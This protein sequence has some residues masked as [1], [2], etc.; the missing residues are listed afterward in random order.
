MSDLHNML[1]GITVEG[2]S[3]PINLYD[4][5]SNIRERAKAW[6]SNLGKNGY[7][8]SQRLEEYLDNLTQNAREKGLLT[9]QEAFILLC[10][11]YLHD[12]GYWLNDHCEAVGHPERSRD[13]VMDNPNEYLL[14]DF[15]CMPERSPRVAEA[16]GLVCYGHSEERFR[17]LNEIPNDFADHFLSPELL[18]LRKLAALLR[19]ADEA[20]DPYIRLVDDSYHP[21]RAQT[22][23]VHIGGETIVWHWKHAGV[24]NPIEFL[25]H[26]TEKQEALV[27]SIDYLRDLGL[28]YWYLVLYPQVA[29]AAP[30]MPEDSVE[31]FVGREKDIEALHEV[32]RRRREGAITG[33]VGT[34]GIG[35]TE[36]AKM[37]AKR[38]RHEYLGGIFWASLKGSDWKSQAEKILKELRPG[39]RPLVFLDEARAK[40]AITSALDRRDGLLIIDNVTEL[41]QIV[42]PGCF[43]LV[44]S[45]DRQVFGIIPNEGIR[46]LSGLSIKEGIQLLEKILSPERV[47]IDIKAAERIIEILGGLPLAVEIAAKQLADA[48]DLSFS[49]YIGSVEGKIQKL[50]LEGCPDKDVVTSLEL[51]LE[52]L[53]GTKDGPELI[54]LFAALGVCAPSGFTSQTLGAA[55]G[56]REM[57]EVQIKKLVGKLYN[58]SLLEYI[59]ASMFFRVHPLLRQLAE[60][61]LN[62]DAKRAKLFVKNHCLHFLDYA[63]K[64]NDNPD[65]LIAE[66][67]G[68]WQA[69]IKANQLDLSGELLP[70]F[71]ANISRPYLTLLEDRKHEDAFRYLGKTILTDFNYIWP[72]GLLI[73]LLAPLFKELTALSIDSQA[74]LLVDMG[75][76]YDRLGE[77]R[78]A[79]EIGEQ[80]L[81]IYRKLG[82]LRG[83]G[84]VQGNIGASYTALREY[85][86][87]I[88]FQER[89]LEVF[90]RGTGN[91][92]GEGNALAN[93]GN[94]HVA[95]GDYQKAIGFY[96]QSLEIHR[97]I[98]YVQGQGGHLKGIGSCYFHFGEYQKAIKSY[99]QALRI[100]HRLGQ[101]EDEANCLGGM[102]HAYE[103]LGEYRKAIDL[104]EQALEIDRS[105]G[106]LHG[107]AR[108][109]GN[110]GAS[111][112]YLGEHPRAMEL[113]EQA[114]AL[115]RRLGDLLGEAH[116]LG[117]MGF[118][119]GSLGQHRKAIDFHE[120]AL[121][122][123]RKVGSLLSEGN[124]LGNIGGCYAALGQYRKAINFQEQAL[125]IHRRIGSLNDEGND[126]GDIGFAYEGLGEYKKAIGFYSQAIEIHRRIGNLRGE[127]IG[128][129]N[130]GSAYHALGDKKKA[131]QFFEMSIA[132]FRKLGLD[133]MVEEIERKMKRLN[134]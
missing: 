92:I 62:R 128:L 42:R 109:L 108:D 105:L 80:A 19:L 50:V 26:L 52:Q 97:R 75:V 17:P 53:E 24:E 3:G 74:W 115:H 38:F 71:L 113:L 51:S 81:E 46:E 39:A 33:I 78:K 20:D 48:P 36:T 23:L 34:G 15:R 54:A 65:M 132:V 64:Y 9:P 100:H 7:Q 11:V 110:I 93:I 14:G 41:D 127:G 120:R 84:G 130:M 89:A 111:Y 8:H 21:I 37:Y 131:H 76:A 43:L 4:R 61:R 90:H 114:L 69:M 91:E 25:D 98:G 70:K 122:L 29:G 119:Y 32:V 88:E 87:A 28:G 126:L 96:E 63:K 99:E 112:A 44:T 67:N 30:F 118:T 133:R 68:L 49:Q 18:N 59:P 117:N 10:S 40:E 106:D 85:R 47:R 95:L 1:R 6:L 83:Q 124:D 58:R 2:T 82:H 31:T 72:P 101:R 94:C 86:K 60:V 123:H 12:I 16:V 57:D 66:I 45:R 56:L 125:E 102:S 27:T 107:E 5:I 13:L 134:L 129:A 121:E 77:H 73:E 35:K 103:A 22:P 116:C 104:Q 55:A 79:I